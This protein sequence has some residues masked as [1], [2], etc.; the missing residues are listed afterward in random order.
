MGH[1]VYPLC[2]SRESTTRCAVPVQPRHAT[3][4]VY[5]T[6]EVQATA[7]ACPVHLRSIRSC[8]VLIL[9]LPNR[10]V[11]HTAYRHSC[12]FYILVLLRYT[13][14]F[15]FLLEP[16]HCVGLCPEGEARRGRPGEARKRRA[17]HL[18][19]IVHR[20]TCIIYCSADPADRGPAFRSEHILIPSEHAMRHT[21]VRRR[22]NESSSRPVRASLSCAHM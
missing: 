11:I 6:G 4:R 15:A 1:T 3:Q 13:R 19:P 2:H 5:N 14:L 20:D 21:S 8:V 17:A 10:T 7:S 16:S 18:G 12:S 22:P 9:V